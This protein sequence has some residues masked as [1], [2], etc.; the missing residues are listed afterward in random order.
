[1]PGVTS[2]RVSSAIA[3]STFLA[4]ACSK[5]HI[6]L[7]SRDMAAAALLAMVMWSARCAC[8]LCCYYLVVLLL[9]AAILGVRKQAACTA[10][11]LMRCA[12]C[13]VM[14]RAALLRCTA[15]RCVRG[16]RCCARQLRSR[17]LLCRDTKS[18][19]LVSLEGVDGALMCIRGCFVRA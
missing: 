5:P 12:C 13:G 6:V 17:P 19:V 18:R 9:A 16:A 8:C 15:A 11:Q 1:M 3:A 2:A 14:Q 4:S 10:P 7:R